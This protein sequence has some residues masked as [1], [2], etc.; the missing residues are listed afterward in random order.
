MRN[1]WVWY[2]K[3]DFALKIRTEC[4]PLPVMWSAIGVP[5]RLSS[6]VLA[7]GRKGLVP[8]SSRTAAES[9]V[10]VP[11]PWWAFA[12]VSS[13][14]FIFSPSSE[15]IQWFI[16][17]QAFSRSYDLAS[18]LSPARPTTHRKTEKE[19][20]FVGWEGVRGWTRSEI[21]RRQEGL[22]LYKSFNALCPVHLVLDWCFL[23]TI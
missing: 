19:R 23:K 3:L 21:K 5:G 4:P 16:E 1:C 17:D 14:K 2:H 9:L 15:S 10:K 7:A 18:P 20:Q 11:S 22:A 12:P 6:A 8:L 13:H